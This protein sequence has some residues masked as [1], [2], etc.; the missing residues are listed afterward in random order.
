MLIIDLAKGLS[1]PKK[2]GE[3]DYPDKNQTFLA[4]SAYSVLGG[5]NR[6][7]IALVE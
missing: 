7:N 3:Y 6:I 1:N 2:S 4:K 5:K